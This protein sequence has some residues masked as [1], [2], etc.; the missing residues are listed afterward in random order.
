MLPILVDSLYLILY[1]NLF[2]H[3]FFLCLEIKFY[4]DLQLINT[5][6]KTFVRCDNKTMGCNFRLAQEVFVIVK[7]FPVLKLLLF[8][9]NMLVVSL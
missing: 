9:L 6:V 5:G 1:M 4:A 7:I 2:L 8:V 3:Y